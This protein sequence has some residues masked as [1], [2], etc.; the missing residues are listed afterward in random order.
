[1]VNSNYSQNKKILALDLYIENR[2]ILPRHEFEAMDRAREK[3][4]RVLRLHRLVSSFDLFLDFCIITREIKN[5]VR[6]TAPKEKAFLDNKYE[7]DLELSLLERAMK[8]YFQSLETLRFEGNTNN[9]DGD[10]QVLCAICKDEILIGSRVI[11]MP[12]SHLY[13]VFC[14]AEWLKRSL[15]CPLCR[16]NLS[17]T[18]PM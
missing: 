16:F 6:D 5:H 2:V 9:V 1:M 17:T 11:R 18:F 14:I 15:M 8:D 10:E 4:D 12:C 3:E 7:R 13:H